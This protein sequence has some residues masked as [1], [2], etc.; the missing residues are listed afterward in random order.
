MSTK[1]WNFTEKLCLL[2]KIILNLKVL[3]TVRL[4]GSSMMYL[5]GQNMHV[6]SQ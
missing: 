4:A 3:I 6:H 2:F 5:P 1:E